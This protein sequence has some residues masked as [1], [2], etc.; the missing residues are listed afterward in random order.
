[1][2]PCAAGSGGLPL[3]SVPIEMVQNQCLATHF[4]KDNN[5]QETTEERTSLCSSNGAFLALPPSPDVVNKVKLEAGKA[6]GTEVQGQ[7]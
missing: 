5:I 4:I 6:K 7:S 1:M 3:W 2:I